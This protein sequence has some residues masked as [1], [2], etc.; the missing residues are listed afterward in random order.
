MQVRHEMTDKIRRMRP[1]FYFLGLL[2]GLS[3]TL[4]A[5]RWEITT[6]TV[7]VPLEVLDSSE[8]IEMI[9]FKFIEEKEHEKTT[10]TK[11]IPPDPNVFKPTEK[12]IVID[13]GYTEKVVTNPFTGDKFAKPDSGLGGPEVFPDGN[14]IIGDPSHFPYFEGGDKEWADFINKNL[15]V[16]GIV[17]EMNQSSVNIVIKCVVEK[18][19][20]LSNFSIAK[21]G[22]SVEAAE[23]FIETLKKSPKW[24]PGYQGPRPVRVYVYV[25]LKIK[26]K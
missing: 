2:I 19:G 14:L 24:V 8:V 20:S 18:D 16:P 9:D 15:I 12:E 4:A 25:P 3:A 6:E 21:D 17:R 10:K 1:T 23:A 5:F 11:L 13:T 7:K 26:L 22:G